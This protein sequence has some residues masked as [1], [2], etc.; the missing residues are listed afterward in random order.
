M[1]V[2]IR[3]YSLSYPFPSR[4]PLGSTSSILSLTIIVYNTLQEIGLCCE[5]LTRLKMLYFI[6]STL[7]QVV[8]IPLNVPRGT[9]IPIIRAIT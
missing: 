9:Y 5:S 3:E 8:H 4:H 1:A 6:V 7:T 2:E